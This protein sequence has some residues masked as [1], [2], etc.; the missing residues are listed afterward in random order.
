MNAFLLKIKF[1]FTM[2]IF[3][4]FFSCNLI[5]SGPN[6]RLN[7]ND[8]EAQISYF[9]AFALGTDKV[10]TTWQWDD[11]NSGPDGNEIIE[12]RVLHS[13][14]T[15]PQVLLPFTGETITD[16]SLNE[17]EWSGLDVNTTHYFALYPKDNDERWYAPFY[18]EATLPGGTLTTGNFSIVNVWSVDN[19]MTG[20]NSGVTG[21]TIADWQILVLEFNIPSEYHILSVI[22][23]PLD[24]IGIK[25]DNSDFLRIYPLNEKFDD[26]D[27]MD[28]AWIQLNDTGSSDY[29]VEDFI[30]NEI[31]GQTAMWNTSP[32][33]ITES[34]RAAALN[35][36]NQLVIK[37]VD[38]TM[39][40]FTDIIY[41]DFL[42]IEYIVN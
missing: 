32:L 28:H 21:I 11:W 18:A 26:V 3:I 23:N 4:F 22:I 5:I 31:P 17:F 14:L 20:S 19:A 36:S 34:V 41:T 10:L 30:F 15:Y 13:T 27:I 29:I 9:N 8:P 39:S 6:S 33:D 42:E 35:G 24:N 16:K 2:L 40:T 37:M 12:I 38:T 7:V 1:L 25:T